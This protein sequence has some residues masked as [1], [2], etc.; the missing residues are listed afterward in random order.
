[1]KIGVLAVQGSFKEHIKMLRKCN[2]DFKEVK[3]PSDLNDI[4]GLIL[5]GGEST[6]MSKLMQ[7]YKLDKEIKK[8]HNEGMPIF[9]TCAGT[10]LMAKEIINY[11]QTSPG[12]MNISVRKNAYGRQADSF[13][14]DIEINNLGKFK[15]VFIRAPVIE[16]IYNGVEVLSEFNGKAV[17]VRNGNLLAATFHPELTDDTRLHEYFIKMV[18][19]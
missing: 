11:K 16:N 12:L 17:L 19:S 15:G 18:D 14:A 13:E 10:I 7:K 3:L 4:D 1:M 9:G 6:A 2:V 8:R 5:P